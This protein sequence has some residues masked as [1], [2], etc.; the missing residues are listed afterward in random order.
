MSPDEPKPQTEATPKNADETPDHT[1]AQ[2]P[3]GELSE[4][5]LKDVSGGGHMTQ[6]AARLP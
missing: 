2:K 1:T 6:I 5:Q 4:E 3:A